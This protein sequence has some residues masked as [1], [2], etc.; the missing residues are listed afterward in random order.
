[1]SSL[2]IEFRG[3][4]IYNP[5]NKLNHLKTEEWWTVSKVQRA[6]KIGYNAALLLI[7]YAKSVEVLDVSTRRHGATQWRV[8]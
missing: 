3:R 7:Q 5:E 4:K 6:F 8:K 1:M 2:C